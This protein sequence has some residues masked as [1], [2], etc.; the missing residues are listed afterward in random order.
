MFQM[1][2]KI[3]AD[4]Q[5]DCC[6]FNMPFFE[7]LPEVDPS[8]DV[9]NDP[10]WR[11][12]TYVQRHIFAMIFGGFGCSV[13]LKNAKL[14][15]TIKFG[16]VEK[17][18]PKDK[19]IDNPAYV[20]WLGL[21]AQ[22]NILL[23]TVFA[24]L[25]NYPMAAYLLMNGLK[26]RAVNLFLPYCD[27]IK[28]ILVKVSDMPSEPAEYFGCGFSA[29]EPMGGIELNGGTLLANMAEMII[30]A[31]EGDDGEQILAFRGNQIYGNLKRRGST[32]SHNFRNCIDIYDV[33]LVTRQFKIKRLRL[34]FNGYFTRENQYLIKLP[35]GFHLNPWSE[36]A[37]FFKVLD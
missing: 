12:D 1:D 4:L 27:F 26:S 6:W 15:A 16:Q 19:S 3:F 35:Q 2:E 18:C 11:N 8:K 5:K 37:H 22:Y 23:G 28:Y 21:Y 20:R 34:Y 7:Q 25:H 30:P 24:Y 33:L 17:Q 32:N 31:L 29:D 10:I 9:L 36:E 14:L 13:D